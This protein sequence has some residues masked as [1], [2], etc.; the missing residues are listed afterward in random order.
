[1]NHGM[2]FQVQ[3]FIR[4]R[5]WRQLRS[6]LLPLLD[7]YST[8]YDYVQHTFDYPIYWIGFGNHIELASL[9]LC[10][11]LPVDTLDTDGYTMFHGAS[12]R[13]HLQLAEMLLDHSADVNVRDDNGETPLMKAAHYNQPEMVKMLLEHSADVN[14]RNGIG[15]TPLMKAA[16]FNQLEVV[17]ML[18]QGGADLT[19]RNSKGLTALGIASESGASETEAYLK[20]LLH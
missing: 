2:W 14:V 16:V 5:N 18:V 9:L 15:D 8:A 4:N 7:H 12:R 1:M 17:K 19:V 11:G 13:G 6:H 10:A 3:E 20:R